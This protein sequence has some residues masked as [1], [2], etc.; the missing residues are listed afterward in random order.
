MEV[1]HSKTAVD[2]ILICDRKLNESLGSTIITDP[3]LLKAPKWKKS[4]TS[5]KTQNK[6]ENAVA[7]PPTR[8]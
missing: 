4:Y 8:S 6:V 2:I 1:V 3:S 7:N 5:G